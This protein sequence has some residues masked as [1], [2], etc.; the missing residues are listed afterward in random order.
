MPRRCA[1]V[2]RLT[3][4]RGNAIT[5]W[6]GWNRVLYI[7]LLVMV[8]PA[9]VLLVEATRFQSPVSPMG[10]AIGG[11]TAVALYQ[12]AP[13]RRGSLRVWR[14]FE[15]LS[16]TGR[17]RFALGLCVAGCV[18]LPMIAMLAGRPVDMMWHDEFQFHLQ[19]Q[20]VARGKLW[21]PPHPLGEFFDTFY[22]L[23]EPKYAPQSFPGAAIMFAPTVWLSLPT[24]VMPVIAAAIGAGLT[25][26]VLAEACGAGLALA[27]WVVLMSLPAYQGVA[28]MYLAQMPVLVLCLGGV[29]AAMRF[30]KT[31]GFGA[32][33]VMGILMGWSA[34]TRP[35]DAACWGVVIVAMLLPMLSTTRIA[36]L[37]SAAAVVIACAAPLLCV[38]LVFNYA[39]TGSVVKTPFAFYNERDQPALAFADGEAS[40]RLPQSDIPQKQMFYQSFTMQFIKLDQHPSMTWRLKWQNRL[41]I[42]QPAWGG[43]VWMIPIACLGL[44]AIGTWNRLLLFSILPL[45]VAGYDTYPIFLAHYMTF[46]LP[47][48]VL[49]FSLAPVAVARAFP[50]RSR[51]VVLCGSALVICGMAVG[52]SIEK[53]SGERPNYV[54]QLLQETNRIIAPVQA[55]A[56]LLFTPPRSGMD[57][58][59]E[60][61]YNDDVA[62]PDDAPIIRAHDRGE[63]NIRLY[64]YYAEHQPDRTVWRFDRTT[65]ALTRLGNVRELA[66]GGGAP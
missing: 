39:I 29:L 52:A 17:N 9:A 47:G 19:S 44:L 12:L 33:G 57:V 64:Q 51:L 49:L 26:R 4:P 46:A 24:W 31:R 32:A 38:Q 21:M 65:G 3:F 56:I 63:E 16:R 42:L 20:L 23:M 27:G 36:R 18:I 55:P 10:M 45:F 61:V 30:R 40:K 62:W 2:S 60:H 15:R 7:L 1:I 59:L 58:H 28:T 43:T 37:V 8:I 50:E 48:W 11:A 14:W 6:M 34:I 41:D 53:V 35:L 54:V 66:S 5:L 25:W 22:V 13:L